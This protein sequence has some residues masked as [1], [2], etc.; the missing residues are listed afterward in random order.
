MPR[1]SVRRTWRRRPRGLSKPVFAEARIARAALVAAARAAPNLMP[2]S[3]GLVVGKGE[4]KAVDVLSTA[5]CDTAS[6]VALLNGIARGD[7]INER[8]GR[9]VT[10]K[11][12]QFTYTATV[13]TGTGTDQRQRVL[14]VYDRQTNGAALT[15]AQV[16]N[17]A[18][19]LSPRNLENRRR[20]KI[21]YDRTHTLN[22]SGETGSAVTRRFFRRLAHPVTFN[23]GDAG[24]VADITT[25]S[26]YLVVV[27][28][29][30]A[31]VTAGAVA[32][33][34][35]IRYVDN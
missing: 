12:I 15:A 33:S 17:A 8:T 9:E 23:S 3:R 28:S 19:T 18:D 13:T 25:G 34:S 11:S 24:T 4:F 30:A 32:Y 2:A 14:L 5:T 29:N 21:L 10:M 6:A 31:G 35:R 7:E 26:L 1:T 16:L 20:F 27:G 22:A